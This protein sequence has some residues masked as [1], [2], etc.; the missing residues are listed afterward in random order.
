MAQ[1]QRR[2]GP[3]TGE[4]N[5]A[6]TAQLVQAGYSRPQAAR[7]LSMANLMA[8]GGRAGA[9]PTWMNGRDVD[10]VADAIY[11]ARQRERSIG[12][13]ILSGPNM[14]SRELDAEL[15]SQLS[16][17]YTPEQARTMVRLARRSFSQDVTIPS[18]YAWFNMSDFSRVQRIM[19]DALENPD[20]S[21]QLVAA[22]LFRGSERRISVRA[23]PRIAPSRLHTYRITMGR[24][25]FEI[26]TR[27][28]IPGRGL[29]TIDNSRNERLRT[30]LFS[31]RNN[32]VA[33]YR[34]SGSRRSRL[35][36]SAFSRFR[37]EYNRRWDRTR[38]ALQS[39][40]TDPNLIVVEDITREARRRRG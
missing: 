22:P 40:G 30:E 26:E 23:T 39:T 10:R 29:Q 9:P 1:R 16:R 35:S 2:Q 32:I 7:I 8:R 33:V 17:K 37:S 36:S 14:S 11:N 4:I 12:T 13:I 38:T 19:R 21:R 20:S 6:V 3:S 27:R 25:T 24:S 34:V 18:S 15:T 31:D 28:P 5:A